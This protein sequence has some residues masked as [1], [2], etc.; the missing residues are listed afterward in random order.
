MQWGES[1]EIEDCMRF[2]LDFEDEQECGDQTTPMEDGE[3]NTEDDFAE[4]DDFADFEEDGEE[5]M[6]KA[7]EY[8]GL[9]IAELKMRLEAEKKTGII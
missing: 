1:G 4:N 8:Y 6:V 2:F 9:T 3:C 5:D 7:T